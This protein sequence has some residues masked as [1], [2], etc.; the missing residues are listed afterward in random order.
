M[1]EN[2]VTL[3]PFVSKPGQRVS[4]VRELTNQLQLHAQRAQLRAISLALVA[5]VDLEPNPVVSTCRN[6]MGELAGLLSVL[7][8]R[9]S[10]K[11]TLRYNDEL[12]ELAWLIFR[13]GYRIC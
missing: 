7:R 11:F 12:N 10:A 8:I 4:E 13:T 6:R 9:N 5:Y 1:C 2:S 3:R